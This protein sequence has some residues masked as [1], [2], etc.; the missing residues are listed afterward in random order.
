MGLVNESTWPTDPSHGRLYVVTGAA[1]TALS[2]SVAYRTGEEPFASAIEL[3]S[4]DAGKTTASDRSGG[5]RPC[6]PSRCARPDDSQRDAWRGM[7]HLLSVKGG[8][9]GADLLRAVPQA[10]WGKWW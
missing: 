1:P 5:G 4:A 6:K 9:S 2:R 8:L 7:A 10:R 3:R